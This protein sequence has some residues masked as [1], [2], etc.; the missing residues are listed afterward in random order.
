MLDNH[1][2]PS[3]SPPKPKGTGF[4]FS[5]K[6]SIVFGVFAL[7]LGVPIYM[8]L[9]GSPATTSGLDVSQ[10]PDARAGSDRLD[11]RPFDGKGSRPPWVHLQSQVIPGGIDLF[12][13]GVQDTV[14]SFGTEAIVNIVSINPQQR[15]CEYVIGLDSKEKPQIANLRFCRRLTFMGNKSGELFAQ[16]IAEMQP[17][18][19]MVEEAVALG[20]AQ[21]DNQFRFSEIA[22]VD[23]DSPTDP[24]TAGKP[25]APKIALS[26]VVENLSGVRRE[27]AQFYFE[28]FAEGERIARESFEL[29]SVL[30]S[31]LSRF[32]VPLKIDALPDDC[33][34]KFILDFTYNPRN[35]GRGFR[36]HVFRDSLD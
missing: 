30:P 29:D 34:I 23:L 24:A 12:S 6:D 9:Y 28:I 2:Q 7:L 14:R 16:Q 11:A 33:R 5:V 3:H 35:D 1:S 18:L 4:R 32:T 10:I 20:E 15:H 27:K 25:P 21:S 17:F 19:P 31:G 8:S 22:V 13:H 26:G 36:K